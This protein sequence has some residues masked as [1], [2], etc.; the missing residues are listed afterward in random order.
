MKRVGVCVI[1]FKKSLSILLLF[2]R[3]VMTERC[4]ELQN[5]HEHSLRSEAIQTNVQSLWQFFFKN[6]LNK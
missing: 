4:G 1:I 3:V 2:F 6:F 5:G